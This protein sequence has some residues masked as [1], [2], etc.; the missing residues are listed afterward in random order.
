MRHFKTV[1]WRDSVKHLATDNLQ[2]TMRTRGRTRRI[3][4]VE[5]AGVRQ[6]IANAAAAEASYQSTAESV[7]GARAAFGAASLAASTQETDGRIHLIYDSF[8]HTA[9]AGTRS[10]ATGIRQMLYRADPYQIDLQVELQPETNR[11]VVTGQLMDLG[12]P[13]MFGRGV[14]VMLSDGREFIVN[15]VTNEFGEFRSEVKNSGDL[16][17]SLLGL[18]GKPIVILLRSVLDQSSSAR[19]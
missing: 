11:L 14:Q 15:T 7:H 6:R 2:R 18:S 8:S 19:E 16:E 13:E 3:R 17:L 12:H 1:E 4:D 10:A 5:T 9:P